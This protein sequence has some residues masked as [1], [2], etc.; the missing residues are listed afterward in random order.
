MPCIQVST[1]DPGWAFTKSYR[2][3]N[4]EDIIYRRHKDKNKDND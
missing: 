1:P 4:T 3:K 2:N